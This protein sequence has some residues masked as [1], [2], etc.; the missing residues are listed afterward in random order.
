MFTAS[1]LNP[2][3]VGLQVL[4]VPKKQEDA[5]WFRQEAMLIAFGAYTRRD[6]LPLRFKRRISTSKTM[7]LSLLSRMVLMD[8][9]GK[10]QAYVH[11]LNLLVV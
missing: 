6:S 11:I 4:Y 1:L 10:V 5:I 9:A 3:T 2:D 8:R 7:L